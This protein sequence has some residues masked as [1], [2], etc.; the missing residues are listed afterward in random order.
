MTRLKP[1]PCFIF[2]EDNRRRALNTMIQLKREVA[3]GAELYNYEQTNPSIATKIE[4]RSFA[5]HELLRTTEIIKDS[6]HAAEPENS[7]TETFLDLQILSRLG[8]VS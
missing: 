3:N 4:L 2:S 7:R 1:L 8:A 6:N 5:S